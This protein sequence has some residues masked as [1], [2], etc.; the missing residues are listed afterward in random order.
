M[1][2]HFNALLADLEA[3]RR[4][5][6]GGLDVTAAQPLRFEVFDYAEPGLLIEAAATVLRESL[7]NGQLERT[8]L[9]Y[10]MLRHGTEDLG[11]WL[12]SRGVAV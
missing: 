12:R 9:A 2:P 5:P 11:R 4:E 8:R 3:L 1:S 10:Q 6:S 7:P